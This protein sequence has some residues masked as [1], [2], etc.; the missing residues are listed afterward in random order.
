[1]K[2]S[3][4]GYVEPTK[5]VEVVAAVEPEKLEEFFDSIKDHNFE[6]GSDLTLSKTSDKIDDDK[7]RIAEVG[8][9]KP[10]RL[11][12]FNVLQTSEDIINALRQV[13]EQGVFDFASFTELLE[14]DS[15]LNNP[16]TAEILNRFMG[17]YDFERKSVLEEVAFASIK[18]AINVFGEKRDID[19]FN[20]LLKSLSNNTRF[21]RKIG[22]NTL[23]KNF[24]EN[25]IFP[26]SIDKTLV[27]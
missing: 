22:K 10:Y 19:D 18:K 23:L 16:V 6:E 5:I 20:A 17:L 25:L 11:K 7:L 24:A 3:L 4:I 15:K 12:E 21:L 13:S 1:M 9:S 8:K 26:S 27:R 14:S 2:K